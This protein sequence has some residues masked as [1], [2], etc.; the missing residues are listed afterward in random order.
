MTLYG[1]RD[2]AGRPILQIAM[3]RSPRIYA[4]VAKIA[5]SDQGNYSIFQ[6]KI[7]GS[8]QGNYSIF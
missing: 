7:A 5:G 6:V 4:P 3:P 8:G 2:G 1:K